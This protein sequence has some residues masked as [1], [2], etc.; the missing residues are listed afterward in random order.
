MPSHPSGATHVSIANKTLNFNAELYHKHEAAVLDPFLA[1]DSLAGA[2]TSGC[3]GHAPPQAL[4][5]VKSLKKAV[6]AAERRLQSRVK[7]DINGEHLHELG[8][9]LAE[10]G[11]DA[12][13]LGHAAQVASRHGRV[14]ARNDAVLQQAPERLHLRHR[15]LYAP[16]HAPDTL[17]ILQAENCIVQDSDKRAVS[18][19][20]LPVMCSCAILEQFWDIPSRLRH[21]P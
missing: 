13:A 9:A 11:H 6:R 16:L 3:S 21:Q 10:L 19:K 2:G 4:V 12:R 5:W 18:L 15:L 20:P 14:E 8:F 7:E 1:A 17:S